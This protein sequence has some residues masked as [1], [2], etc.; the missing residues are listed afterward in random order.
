MATPNIVLLMSDQQKATSLGLYGNPDVRTP[1]LE[2]LAAEGVLNQ[3][4]FVQHPLCFPSRCTIMT[5]RYPHAHGVTT[6]SRPLPAAERTLAELLHDAGYQ[7]GVVG[8]F[9]ANSGGGRGF[10]YTHDMGEGVLRQL[11]AERR[12][13]AEAQPRRVQHMV[14]QTA[15]PPDEDM[16]GK[17]TEL[18]LGFLD[19]TDR[20][21]PFFLQIAWI[22]PHPPFFAPAPYDTHYDRAG[23][24][25]PPAEPDFAS[26]PPAQ[27]Q[28]A[29]DMG[30]LDA[31]EAE[32]RDAL[33]HYYGMVSHLDDQVGRVLAY[34]DREG[35]RDNTIIVFTSDHG[36]YAGEHHMFGKSCTLYDCLVRVPLVLAGPTNLVPSGQVVGGLTQ[37]VDLL[38]TLLDLSGIAVPDNVQGQSWRTR[39]EG[40]SQVDDMVFAQVG[41]QP[42]E[43]VSDPVRG[44]N[45]PFGPPASG[46]QVELSVMARTSEWKLV[47]TP[48]R[49][50]N[51]LYHLAEDP[52][53]LQ[54]RYA[55]AA[56][57]PQVATLLRS[58]LDWRLETNQ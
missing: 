25:L 19:Q 33:A 32:V 18:G 13:L 4:Y 43:M 44:N 31:P 51:E 38:P 24:A 50:T 27:R 12:M 47:Y 17:I 7:N 57:Q 23:L 3:H 28:T 55:R 56:D 6:N 10:D 40:D 11:W 35:L 9:H 20:A 15:N 2:A 46:R 42:P 48:G 5:G 34:L 54:N 53:E 36:D 26:K 41:A 45:I 49:E 21:R 37:S 1:V 14:A 29:Q 52:W 39:W 8:H 22:D 58:L 16:N 30:T